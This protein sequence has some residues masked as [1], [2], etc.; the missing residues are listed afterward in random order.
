M[1]PKVLKMASYC[2]NN[3]VE[4][5]RQGVALLRSVEKSIYSAV[6]FHRFS[7]GLSTQKG[8][9]DE[10]PFRDG[11]LCLRFYLLSFHV[12]PSFVS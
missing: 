10:C 5:H 1:S 8:H 4:I 2:R 9:H 12:T 3:V 7:I 6:V 11:F